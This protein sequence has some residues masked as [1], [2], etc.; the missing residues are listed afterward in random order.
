[1]N[2]NI[3]RST[4]SSFN[5]EFNKINEELRVHFG[6][7]QSEI[8]NVKTKVNELVIIVHND[9]REWSVKRICEYIAGR[10]DD[11]ERFGFSA[12]TISN[13][14]NEENKQLIRPK[15]EKFQPNP[16]L[17]ALVRGQEFPFIVKVD[18]LQKKIISL[19]LDQK[20]VKIN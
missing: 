9:N 8:N 5:T 18:P 7:A 4:D 10:N 13:Y 12:K 2:N 6:A 16:E 15:K 19:E 17:E 3:Q 20:K 14:L 11:L 1:M